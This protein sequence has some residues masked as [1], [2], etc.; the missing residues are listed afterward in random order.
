[1]LKPWSGKRRTFDPLL[2]KLNRFTPRLECLE[3]RTLLSGVT[4][5]TVAVQPTTAL[6]S[7][8]FVDI[9]GLTANAAGTYHISA[10]TDI[11]NTSATAGT[12]VGVQLLANGQ[13]VDSRV[14]SFAPNS[15]TFQQSLS[16]EANLVLTAG[17][18]VEVR[19]TVLGGSGSAQYPGSTQN[20]RLIRFATPPVVTN[21]GNQASKAGDSITLPIA[22]STGGPPLVYSASGLPAGLAINSATGVISGTIGNHAANP[23]PYNVTVSASDG[24]NSGNTSVTWS[25]TN[26]STAVSTAVLLAP[27]ATSLTVGQ[28]LATVTHGSTP[29]PLS[30][31]VSFFDGG[32]L[33]GTVNLNSGGVATLTV[34]LAPGGHSITA[35][36]PATDPFLGSTSPAVEVTVPL[37]I[38]ANLITRRIR[39]KKLLFI[40]VASNDGRA[41]RDIL[42]PFQSPTFTGIR[43]TVLQGGN[44]LL[45]GKKGTRTRTLTLAV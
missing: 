12:E 44:V 22:A 8:A 18:L 15:P 32:T 39:K 3:D 19:A 29:Q 9:P 30:G 26:V 23:A 27:S 35:S 33:L 20:L 28:L 37:Q 36:F 24:F 43:L 1:V 6:T 38:S 5:T 2:L 4:L 45:R 13:V 41:A 25:V 14:L 10:A 16:L 40:H 7:N 31:S 17:E 42:S 21:P 34:A 11:Q